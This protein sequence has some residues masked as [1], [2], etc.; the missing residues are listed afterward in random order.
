MLV[1]NQTN[2]CHEQPA[3]V[4]AGGG[5]VGGG[6][7]ARWGC[8]AS[9]AL[10]QP[11]FLHGLA[12]SVVLIGGCPLADG[13]MPGSAIL[14]SF[15]P[16][17]R[18]DSTTLQGDL[19][20]HYQVPFA[21]HSSLC[22]PSVFG[23]CSL[24]I[25]ATS[26]QLWP[27][28]HGVHRCYIVTLHGGPLYWESCPAI[29]CWAVFCGTACEKSLGA[30]HDTQLLYTVHDSQAYSSEGKKTTQYT[31]NLGKQST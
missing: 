19:Q 20:C 13:D 6:W 21:C 25:Q 22:L 14:S 29:G 24:D 10:S 18:V 11:A 5:G 7:V 31:L 27:L 30:L 12:D 26:L 3:A 2:L 17:V 8:V 15:F 28:Q 9:S 4:W 23:R 16:G 1:A